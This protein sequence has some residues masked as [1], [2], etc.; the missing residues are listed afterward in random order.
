MELAD[1]FKE[2]ETDSAGNIL[3]DIEAIPDIIP[4]EG[5]TDAEKKEMED[6]I[7]R[8]GQK[9]KITI[10]NLDRRGEIYDE[11]CDK[12]VSVDEFISFRKG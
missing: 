8:L 12:A 9:Q 6:I 5:L 4:A 11:L 1:I 7:V 2:F 10:I 3:P